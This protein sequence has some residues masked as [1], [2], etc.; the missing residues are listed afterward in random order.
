MVHHQ[1]DFIL[2]EHSLGAAFF[3]FIDGYRSGHVVAQ[4][5]IQAGL[6]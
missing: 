5:Q 1:G 4:H 2:A 6:D 3:K